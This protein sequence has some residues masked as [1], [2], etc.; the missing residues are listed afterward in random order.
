M[1]W[2]YKA[3]LQAL[4]SRSPRSEEVNHFFQSKVTRRLPPSDSYFLYRLLH[5]VRQWSKAVEFGATP[6]PQQIWY[7]FGAGHHLIGPL[8]FYALG[9]ER[10]I[11]TDVTRLARVELV[12]HSIKQFRTVT[13]EVPLVRRPDSVIPAGQGLEDT[14][15]REYHIEY[16]APASVDDLTIPNGSVDCITSTATLEHVPPQ[17]IPHIL[18]ACHRILRPDGIMIHDIDYKDHYSYFDSSI[19]KYNFLKYSAAQWNRYNPSLHYQNRLRHSDCVAMFRASG[20]EVV[21]EEVVHATE[22]EVGEIE[23]LGLHEEFKRYDRKDLLI[24]SSLVVLKKTGACTPG[25]PL[26]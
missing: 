9:V 2:R 20:F 22:R 25:Q 12:N 18:A 13:H 15:E 7:E 16:R 26:D 4:I 11:V 19:S 24:G 17:E 3:L 23:R 14:L 6:L 5:A 10:Q 1:N 21:D 8:G